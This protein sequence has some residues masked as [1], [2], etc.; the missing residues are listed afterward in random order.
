MDIRCRA[1]LLSCVVA[2]GAAQAVVAEESQAVNHFAAA[3]SKVTTS[4]RG[5][6]ELIGALDRVI[7]VVLRL[8]NIPGLNI[9]LARGGRIVWEGAYG[10]SDARARVPMGAETV[11]HSGSIAKPYAA[12]A[13]MQLVERGVLSLDDPI[14]RFLP[15]AVRNPLGGP[16][17][18]IRHLLTHTSG[19]G[20]DSAL[21]YLCEDAR[22]VRPLEELLRK[23]YRY[24]YGQA[25]FTTW[26]DLHR[27]WTEPTGVK[28]QYSNLGAA[29]LGLIVERTN[30]EHL[31]YSEYVQKHIMDP[32][33]MRYSQLPPAETKAL[34]RPEIWERMSTGYQTM[35][36]AWIPTATVCFGEFPCGGALGIPS[37][38]LRLLIM[39][40]QDG[41][42]DGARILKEDSV[43]AMLTVQAP[44]SGGLIWQLFNWGTDNESF[45][46]DGG[47]MWGWRTVA[48][49]YPKSSTAF[50]AAVNSWS[51]LVGDEPVPELAAFFDAW[52]KAERDGTQ[53][54]LLEDWLSTR[55]SYA[56]SPAVPTVENGS[57]KTSYL[58]GLLYAESYQFSI[59]TPQRISEA[60]ARRAVAGTEAGL[61]GW[62]PALW[63]AD[64]FLAGVKDMTGVDPTYSAIR[65]FAASR[66]R[67]T[68]EEARTLYPLLAPNSQSKAALGD[69]L[70][71]NV[72][73][74]YPAAPAP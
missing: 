5:D 36:G 6:L 67:M 53:S 22:T 59:G 28:Y 44:S 66:M 7:P 30:P 15:F 11:F 34:V 25:P 10:Y 21:S 8:Y 60:E 73:S 48:R 54:E 3:Q 4:A 16:P 45:G 20:N 47:H 9:A 61:S 43:R 14:D 39:M 29:T 40:L 18:T 51:S 49:A 37:D 74:S 68:L 42:F 2:F 52:L 24:H 55:R 27:M 38:Y 63:D 71:T 13:V 33:G 65:D 72:A 32:L 1:A 50:M 31:S 17:I 70:W 57:W 35:G 26:N 56:P 46:H 41:V 19:L 69:L 64:G 58:R 62:Q 23:A 12:V